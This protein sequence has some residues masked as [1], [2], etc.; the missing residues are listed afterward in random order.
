ME[1]IGSSSLWVEKYRPK[2][3]ADLIAPADLHRFLKSVKKD[4]DVPN[5]LFNGPAGTGKTTTAIAIAEE[6]GASYLHLNASINRSINDIRYQV[7]SFATTKSLVSDSRKIAILDEF[8]RL[9]PE[10]MD[11][12]KGLIEETE[13][14]CRYIFITNNIQKVIAPLISRCQQFSFGVDEVGKKDLILQYF[15]RSKYILEAEKIKYD[16]ETVAKFCVELFPD[17]RKI[18]NELQKFSKANGEINEDIFNFLDDAVIRDLVVE[19]KA[20]QFDNVRKIVGPIDPGT[21]YTSF[22]DDLKTYIKNESIPDV[23]VTLAE[24]AFRDSLVVDREINLMACLIELMKSV[25]WK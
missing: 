24:Y 16:K 11:A 9:T 1:K 8:D 14:N 17:M 13:S 20:K 21:F 15:K 10:A 2:I 3:F 7:Q 25:K 23:V 6:L 18:L 5:L 19:M 12:L 4:G 22:Y